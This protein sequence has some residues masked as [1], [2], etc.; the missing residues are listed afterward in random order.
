M[1]KTVRSIA[2]V[3]PRFKKTEATKST[4]DK[5]APQ[6]GGV[7]WL[8]A[9]AVV[10]WVRDVLLSPTR[11]EPVVGITTDSWSGKPW[12]DPEEAHRALEG[13][14]R[15]VALETGDPTWELSS[16]LPKRLD[17]YGGAVR[18]WWPGLHEGSNPYDH[19]LHIIR[20]EADAR[21]A[22]RDLK[23]AIL[24]KR[25]P[26]AIPSSSSG[27]LDA[28]VERVVQSRVELLAGER[29]G[30]LVQADVPLG[31]LVRCMS[32]GLSVQAHILAEGADRR[33]RFSM[34]GLLPDAW[35]LA[36][37]S[38]EVGSVVRARV[39]NLKEFGVFVDV[40]PGVSGLVHKSEV[41]WT[42]VNDVS[43]FAR[44]GDVV[45]VKALE[46]DAAAKTLTLSMKQAMGVEP[47][48]LPH[49]VPGGL[50]FYWEV[51][52]TA[53]G[54]RRDVTEDPA[55]QVGALE[56]ELEAALEE[57][58][59]LE[60]ANKELKAQLIE[61]K[62]QRRSTESK[63]ELLE[64]R[65]ADERDPLKSE[66]SFLL[67]VRLS[68]ARMFGEG[69]RRDHP[70]ERMR[71]GAA[72]LDSVR[73]LEGIEVAKV[74]EVCA[75]VACGAA[76]DIPGR[77][78]HRMRETAAG[79]SNFRTRKSD[80]AQAWRCSLQVN[81]PSARR[82]HWWAVSSEAGNVFEFAAV[83]VHDNFNIPE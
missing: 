18:V 81:T 3:Q 23:E 13:R 71:V 27:V 44:V 34:K 8:E 16:A 48:P 39:Q 2:C 50:P 75:Q 68:Y 38:L 57:R 14:A 9:Q 60:R 45:E 79:G 21:A 1:K 63:L 55:E 74:L 52:D 42:Y 32:D 7:Q 33:C 49:L 31:F 22:L 62:R 37:E 41:D 40:L 82:L 20:S 65:G 28:K 67:G 64:R 66:R 43:E 4:S 69:D 72:F 76:Q 53:F 11:K 70:L 46:I 77:E 36:K 5:P 24:G 17:A 25:G 10:P 59:R 26:D 83:G 29:R 78:V 61:E 47:V 51:G 15:V 80:G 73:E 35:Q 30:D 19:K 54:P 12:V 6:G 56:D 58:A